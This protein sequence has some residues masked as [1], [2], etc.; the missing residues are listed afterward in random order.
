MNGR[1]R[2][3]AHLAGCPVDCLPAMPIT[4]TLAAGA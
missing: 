2:I 3:L 1:E 4:M